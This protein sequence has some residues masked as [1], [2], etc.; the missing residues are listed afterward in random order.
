MAWSPVVGGL[1]RNGEVAGDTWVRSLKRGGRKRG[2]G[3][4]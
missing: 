2:G 3:S 1:S 4:S